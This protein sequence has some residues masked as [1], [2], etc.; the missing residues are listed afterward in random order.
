MYHNKAD[1]TCYWMDY[2]MAI[3][4]INYVYRF[5]K[6]ASIT[7]II[8]L[9]QNKL[10]E[11]T[12]NLWGKYK[13][14]NFVQEGTSRQYLED[15]VLPV[16]FFMTTRMAYM[17]HAGSATKASFLSLGS[18]HSNTAVVTSSKYQ[19]PQVSNIDRIMVSPMKWRG[20]HCRY[21][22]RRTTAR[23]ISNQLVDDTSHKFV[24]GYWLW[25]NLWRWHVHN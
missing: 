23:K 5:H 4:C 12:S 20:R 7:E 9:F 8:L 18:F 3:S 21:W 16:V 25:G 22:A 14:D 15:I 6:F 2:S 13:S 24:M 1:K 17:S 19:Q 10:P 11:S